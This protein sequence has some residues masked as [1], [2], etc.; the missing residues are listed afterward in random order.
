MS[1]KEVDFTVPSD[2][3]V[4]KK[5]RDAIHEASGALQFIADKREFMKDIAAGVEEEYGVPKKVFN[6]MVK[7]FHKQS[8]AVVVQED[9]QFQLFYENIVDAK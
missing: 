9:T 6:K 3:A 8:Y 7:T 4:R 1:D 5:I 2:P